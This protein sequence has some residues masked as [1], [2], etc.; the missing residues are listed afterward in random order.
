MEEGPEG[1]EEGQAGPSHRLK[2]ASPRV[3][4]VGEPL[5]AAV[6]ALVVS[7]SFWWPGRHVVAFDTF[8]YSGPNYRLTLEGWSAGRI[9]L[10]NDLIFGGVTHAGNP[11]AGVFSP[12]KLVGLLF[13]TNTAMNV[14]VALHLV[15]MA[16]ATVFLLRRLGARPPAALGG[17]V[18]MVA[19]GAVLTRSIQFEQI[20]VLAWAPALLWG[21]TSVLERDGAGRRWGA[22]A[23]TAAVTAMVILAGHPQILYQVIVL[24]LAWTVA[25]VWRS[26]DPRRLLDLAGAVA[27]GALASAVHLLAALAATTDSA[28]TSGRDMSALA[29]PLLSAR[30]HHLVQSLLGSVRYVADDMF[31]GGFESIGH[32]GVVGAILAVAGIVLLADDARQRPLAIVLGVTMAVTVVWALGPRTPI[33]RIAYGWLPGFDLARASGRWLGV[34]AVFAAIAAG[35]G[36][37][38]LRR[39]PRGWLHVAVP[40]GSF[41]VMLVLGAIGVVEVTGAAI[42]VPWIVTALAVIALLVGL[43]PRRPAV[44]VVVLVVLLGLEVGAMSRHSSIATSTTATSFDAL[45]AGPAAE[46]S[47]RD[48]LTIAL[49][50]DAWDDT[51]YLVAGLR[52]NTNVLAGVASLDGY[53]GGVQVTERYASLIEQLSPNPEIELPLRNNLPTRLG[54]DVAT[55]L[56]L[57][58]ALVDDRRDAPALLPGWVATD[59]S[60]DTFTVWENPAWLGDAVMADADGLTRPATLEQPSPGHLVVDV[61]VERGADVDRTLVVHRQTAPGWSASVDG[62]DA[63]LVTG[64]GFFLTVEVPAGASSVELQYRPRWLVPGLLASLL[65]VAA[66][67]AMAT[68]AAIPRSRRTREQGD[69]PVT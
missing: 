34:T 2:L 39:R 26:G 1:G 51:A 69:R 10:W 45:D 5:V 23:G 43:V 47:E 68:A 7:R 42:V 18:L 52:P 19:N 15:L 8:A 61:A 48:G 29:S 24:A 30:P 40:A 25:M 32:V 57:R 55:D 22:M 35:L 46:L 33:F 44:A 16:V 11:Q 60:D 9:P 28:I 63:E 17:A 14:T 49:T 62:R 3:L 6:V 36:L 20:I 31:A 38:A 53:D 4:R 41:A 59:M 21:I 65:G 56:G 13:D 12:T 50:D 54:L 58:W 64:D 27:V 37:E 67:A 66:I